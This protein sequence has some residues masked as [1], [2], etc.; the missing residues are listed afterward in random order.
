MSKINDESILSHIVSQ[1]SPDSRDY[2]E[3]KITDCN[4]IIN[5]GLH[6]K[7]YIIIT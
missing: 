1:I 5:K 2:S 3:T 7:L 4:T 6:V